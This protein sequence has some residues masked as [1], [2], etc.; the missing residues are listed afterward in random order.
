MEKVS[1]SEVIAFKQ[2]V[3]TAIA[4]AL[5]HTDEGLTG[6]EIS[7]LLETC[8]IKDVDPDLTK[9]HRLYNAFA[10]DQN[11]RGHRKH[12]LGFIRHA[13]K[14][15]RYIRT[16]N[17]YEPMR[18]RL[19]QALLFAGLIVLESGKLAQTE[20]AG[21]LSESRRRAQ[22]LRADLTSRGVHPD[23]LKFCKEELLA[24][25]YFHAVLEAV[26]SVAD[27]LRDRT[28]LTDDGPALVDRALGGSLPMLAI[29]SLKTDSEQSEQRGFS[30]LVKGAFGMF[31]NPAAHAPR[32]HWAMTKYDAEDLLSLVSLIHRRLDAAHMPPRI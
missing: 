2:S 4:D 9:R 7:H 30:N 24:D 25:D 28:G 11:T 26:K 3:M 6:T 23:V 12:V 19:N 14:P 31:R 5:G 15:E 21:T 22:E 1:E 32:I 8:R 17:R 27:K 13:M 29:N 20:P 18:T 16:P 10:H